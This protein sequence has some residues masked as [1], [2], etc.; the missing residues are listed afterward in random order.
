MQR[1]MTL[2]S[3]T[4]LSHLRPFADVDLLAKQL[5]TLQESALGDIKIVSEQLVPALDKLDACLYFLLNHK[6]YLEA[7]AYIAKAKKILS[8]ALTLIR[9]Y[10]ADVMRTLNAD[11]QRILSDKVSFHSFTHINRC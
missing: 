1:M 7:P 6:D 8:H 10:Y 9:N 5:S 3:S 11:V 2:K 4:Y